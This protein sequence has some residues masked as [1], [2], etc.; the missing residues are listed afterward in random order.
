[1]K[2]AS[3]LFGIQVIILIEEHCGSLVSWGRT[4]E[5]NALVGGSQDPPSR[6]IDWDGIDASFT[7]KDYRDRYFQ[8][9]KDKGYF[10]YTKTTQRGGRK[11]FSCHIQRVAPRRRS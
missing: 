3:I 1:M 5:Y 11:V 10:G 8:A 2:A 9:C 6:H 4:A 7:R